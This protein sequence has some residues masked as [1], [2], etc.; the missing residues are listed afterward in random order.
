MSVHMYV[1]M[2]TSV[3]VCIRKR[4]FVHF[5]ICVVVVVVVVVVVAEKDRPR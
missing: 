5:V 4:I 1:C 3:Y 2:F